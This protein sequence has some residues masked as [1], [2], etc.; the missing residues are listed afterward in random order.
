V[1]QRGRVGP[2][3]DTAV[4]APSPEQPWAAV[5]DRELTSTGIVMQEAALRKGF[6]FIVEFVPDTVTVWAYD[7][8]AWVAQFSGFRYLADGTLSTS[9]RGAWRTT[10]D[11]LEPGTWASDQVERLVADIRGAL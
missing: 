10:V 7:D 4:I 2:V 11:Y 9:S 5:L 3:S 6:K 1:A 8:S